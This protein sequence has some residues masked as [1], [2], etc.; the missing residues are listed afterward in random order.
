MDSDETNK[1]LLQTGIIK[2]L[3]IKDSDIRIM[4]V[5]QARDAVDK[6]MHIGGAF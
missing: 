5:K 4:I 2:L 6:K 1:Y 3:E